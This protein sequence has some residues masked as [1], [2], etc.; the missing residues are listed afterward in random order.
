[1]GKI[2]F[3]SISTSFELYFL[4]VQVALITK[5]VSVARYCREMR[6]FAVCVQILDALEMFMV[7]QLPVS[8]WS[9]FLL[10]YFG[11]LNKIF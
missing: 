3:Y 1:M 9:R 6:N 8:T 2:F 10:Q 5:F 7:R 11:C 4:Q